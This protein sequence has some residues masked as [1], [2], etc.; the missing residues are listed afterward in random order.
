MALRDKAGIKTRAK[1]Q[2]EIRWDEYSSG[3][4]LVAQVIK[5][6]IKHGTGDLHGELS[7]AFR[8]LGRDVIECIVD[9]L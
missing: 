1:T 5:S 6:Q 9:E 8:Q 2:F 3:V 4:K 7:K